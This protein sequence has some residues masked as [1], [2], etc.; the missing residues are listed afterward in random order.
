MEVD[1]KEKQI[2]I[3]TSDDEIFHLDKSL[4]EMSVTIKNMIQGK[5]HILFD[6]LLKIYLMKIQNY[7]F[8]CL[9]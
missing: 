7:P 8:L 3:L 5:I 2:Q 4:V 9:M 6:K 1:N